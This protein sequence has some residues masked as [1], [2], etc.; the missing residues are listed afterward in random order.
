MKPIT[1]SKAYADL[2]YI[3]ENF[4][5]DTTNQLKAVAM[6]DTIPVDTIIF[7]NKY[8]P[9]EQFYTYNKVYENRRKNPL[10]KNLVNENLP[11]AEKAIALSSF[12]TQAMIH[13]KELLRENKED[14]AQK[15]LGVMNIENI[16]EA[17]ND[18]VKGNDE[19]LLGAFD[20]TRNV[21]K[22]LF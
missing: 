16:A 20:E 21:F 19:K 2:K 6:N 9:L 7:I 12:I 14:D 10:Y 18:Y 8:K 4:N 1:K 17:I 13:N 5:V 15:F 11:T 3:K 22:N